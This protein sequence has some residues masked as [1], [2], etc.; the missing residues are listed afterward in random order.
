MKSPQLLDCVAAK[1]NCALLTQVLCASWLFKHP[2]L[3][4]PFISSLFFL[5][6]STF[7]FSSDSCHYHSSIFL[8]GWRTRQYKQ[9]PLLDK[10]YLKYVP[11]EL[12]ESISNIS[13]V[14]ITMILAS[15]PCLLS[16]SGES[17]S[18]KTEACKQIVKHLTC[19]ASSSRSTFDT[20]IKHVSSILNTWVE[21]DKTLASLTGSVIQS[22]REKS[23]AM[24]KFIKGLS[25][26]FKV[27]LFVFFFSCIDLN[28][29]RIKLTLMCWEE[30][31]KW[32]PILVNRNHLCDKVLCPT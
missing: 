23:S 22:W 13:N 1:R 12:A 18:G 10:I 15:L 8:S 27:K 24:L 14:K 25:P 6:L 28:G 26:P 7:F 16:C 19:R 32:S 3:F 9:T 31:K 17:G 4:F 11:T 29:S 5:L 20:K 21:Q 2:F 30:T